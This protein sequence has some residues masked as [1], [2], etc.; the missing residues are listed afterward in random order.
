MYG[1]LDPDKDLKFLS[2]AKIRDYQLLNLKAMTE[3][4][5]SESLIIRGLYDIIDSSNFDLRVY[6]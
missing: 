3:I 5:E 6:Y 1:W 4:L 2:F